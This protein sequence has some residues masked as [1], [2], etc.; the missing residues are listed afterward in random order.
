MKR[1]G[2]ASRH[3]RIGFTLVE[4]LV[5]IAVIAILASLLLPALQNARMASLGTACQSGMRQLGLF[6]TLF[7]QENDERFP[8]G[9][10]VGADTGTRR[11]WD[12]ALIDTQTVPKGTSIYSAPDGGAQMAPGQIGC[13]LFVNGQHSAGKG[14]GMNVDIF[15]LNPLFA[16][17]VGIRGTGDANLESGGRTRVVYHDDAQCAC[18]GATG[19]HAKFMG[20]NETP[21]NESYRIY[22]LGARVGQWRK[23]GRT[24][25]IA[26]VERSHDGGSGAGYFGEPTQNGNT[27]TKLHDLGRCASGANLFNL[28]PPGNNWFGSRR[29]A[30]YNVAGVAPNKWTWYVAFRHLALRSGFV[31]IDGHVE[32]LPPSV[33]LVNKDRYFVEH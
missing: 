33:D 26:E 24:L 19:Y 27:H 10:G 16:Y 29:Y 30:V 3:A 17:P 28:A 15:A 5:V 11:Y 13:P 14:G 6:T 32:N 31:F 22:W 8:G 9:G 4:L 2:T 7:I 25:M 18:A 23:P 1:Y 21:P 20:R 12:S